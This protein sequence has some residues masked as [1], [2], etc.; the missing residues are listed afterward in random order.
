M[1]P[2]NPWLYNHVARTV[3]RLAGGNNNIL[4]MMKQL[5]EKAVRMA[6][7][8]AEYL[9]TLAHMHLLM[10]DWNTAYE[11][12]HAAAQVPLFLFLFHSPRGMC[13][14]W[15]GGPREHQGNDGSDPLSHHEG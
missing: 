1:E 7:H 11:R 2:R 9:C 5:S 13:M 3:G 10:Q 8:N 12:F 6:P 14:C 15:A 4:E